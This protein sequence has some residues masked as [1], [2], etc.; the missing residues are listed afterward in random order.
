M[1]I[2]VVYINE[3]MSMRRIEDLHN[4]LDKLSEDDPEWAI[5][6]S[7]IIQRIDYL[8]DGWSIV[9]LIKRI[10]NLVIYKL[11]KWAKK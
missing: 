7:D 5:M 8:G 4:Y 6:S 2:R 3:Y 9:D 11:W 1:K 10:L